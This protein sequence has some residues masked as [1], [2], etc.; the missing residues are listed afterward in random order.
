MP[1]NPPSPLPSLKEGELAR[2]LNN[3]NTTPVQP[4]DDQAENKKRALGELS[5]ISELLDSTAFQWFFEK[6]LVTQFD[7]YRDLF[8]NPRTKDLHAAQ[9]RFL[10][11]KETVRWLKEREL[12]HRKLINPS[13]HGLDKLRGELKRFE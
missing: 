13:D 5:Q 11:A 7:A 6:C 3:P 2:R 4:A 10:L 1:Q 12:Q 9:A 8:H